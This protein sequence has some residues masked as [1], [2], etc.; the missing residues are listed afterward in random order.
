MKNIYKFLILILAV[1]IVSCTDSDISVDTMSVTESNVIFTAA[2]GSDG[3]I[4]VNSTANYTAVSNQSWCTVNASGNTIAVSAVENIE[5]ESR[6]AIVTITSGNNKKEVSVYQHGNV[7][8]FSL[9]RE[10][11][12]DHTEQ[13]Y[14]ITDIT[15]SV[16]LILTFL[17]D[18][19][20]VRATVTGDNVARLAFEENTGYERTCKLVT[21]SGKFTDTI[22]VT[23]M[24]SLYIDKTELSFET[25]DNDMSTAQSVNVFY[26]N[27]PTITIA[28][29]WVTATL[30]ESTLTVYCNSATSTGRT[31]TIK[32]SLGMIER[33]ITVKQTPPTYA[34]YI[35][36]WKLTGTDYATDAEITYPNIKITQKVEGVSYE[37]EGW[38]VNATLAAQ[39]LEMLFDAATGGLSIKA[40]Q[41]TGSYS[42]YQI[43]LVGIVPYGSGTSLV[44][45][46]YTALKGVLSRGV[47]KWE[48]QTL[49]LSGTPYKIIGVV[50]RLTAN[51]GTSWTY[52]V[53]DAYV[54]N[55]ATLTK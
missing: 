17:P 6:A 8:I 25:S 13:I 47:V 2:G 19:T 7:T 4:K 14:E 11:N 43:H 44:P 31:T 53:N 52:F 24:S 23:Q 3:Y 39:K 41:Q 22:V 30:G 40:T 28:D 5:L 50:Y 18:V 9:T 37:V 51:N 1:A 49:S 42:T 27:T 36:N 48:Y 21:T 38:A 20:W 10:L 55:N 54:L 45:G 16:P 29:S 35:G 46:N 32:L 15:S 12:V 34:D 33:I 26:G